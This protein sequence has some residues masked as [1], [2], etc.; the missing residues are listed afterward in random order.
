[1][2]DW[3]AKPKSLHAR[4]HDIPALNHSGL[5]DCQILA[6]ENLEKSFREDRLAPSVQMPKRVSLSHFRFPSGFIRA[7]RSTCMIET[8]AP[9]CS[10]GRKGE[11]RK[12][13][14]RNN[15][16]ATNGCKRR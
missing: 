15:P 12:S 11:G 16:T 14:H 9:C 5:R 3:L 8:D 1:M 13:A 10:K 2:A 7:I 6:I 4:L